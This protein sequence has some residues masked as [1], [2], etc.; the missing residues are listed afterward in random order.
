MC[1]CP[2]PHPFGDGLAEHQH[3]VGHVSLIVGAQLQRRPLCEDHLEGMRQ[4]RAVEA[5]AT[6]AVLTPGLRKRESTQMVKQQLKDEK[7]TIAYYFQL[8]K[9][10]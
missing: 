2:H 10:G 6:S 1:V 7:S 4:L 5:P 9:R 8:N 3:P